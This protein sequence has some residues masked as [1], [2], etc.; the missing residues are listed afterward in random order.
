MKLTSHHT[1]DVR[2][3]HFSDMPQWSLYVCYRGHSGR[4]LLEA[5]I[6]PF[7]PTE[8]LA[9]PGG[10]ALDAGFSPINGPV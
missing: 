5:S 6:S 7:D 10:S 4:H 8:T 9:A 2:V 3:W 1:A